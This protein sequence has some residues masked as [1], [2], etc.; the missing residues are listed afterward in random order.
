M[1][2]AVIKFETEADRK[3][4]WIAERRTCITGTDVAAILGIS[5]WSSPIQVYLDKKG[6]VEVPE[7]E[8]MR[9]GRRL[10]RPILDGYADFYGIPLKYADP[11]T[12]HKVPDF[13]LLGASLDAI[14]IVDGAP[15]DAKNTRQ[16]TEEWGEDGSDQIPVYYASQLAI[17]MMATR[18][19]FADLAV[20]FSG[21]AF[22]TFRVFADKETEDMIKERVSVWWE[23]H[24][25]QDIPPDVDGSTSSSDYLKKKFARAALVTKE[26]TP[27]VME[28]IKERQIAARIEKEGKEKKILFENYIKNYLG[29]ACAIPGILSWKNNKDGTD[30][31]WEAVAC[32]VVH[33]LRIQWPNEAERIQQCFEMF[34]AQYTESTIG[35]RVL[36]F[37]K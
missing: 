21:Q 15:V 9:W 17:Q 34:L 22:A 14:R 11:W 36:R 24:I 1:P 30:V 8:P 5:K 10:E 16:R 20:L 32:S 33:D 28:W 37:S 2:E 6:L 18:S 35:A 7:N 12:L 19:N 31:N 25:V 23:R 26:A 27:E 4:K 3:A 13:P 29:D